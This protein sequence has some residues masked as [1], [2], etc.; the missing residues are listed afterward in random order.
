M[1]APPLMP[2]FAS[3]T[4]RAWPRSPEGGA[5]MYQSPAI[6]LQSRYATDAHVAGYYVPSV[7]RRLDGGAPG[8]PVDGAPLVV[9]MAFLIIDLDGPDHQAPPAWRSHLAERVE[10]ALA[11][12]P[13][14]FSYETRGGGRLV[15][16]RA[17]PF[18]ITTESDARTWK[19]T[20]WRTLLYLSRRYGLVGDPSCADWTRLYRAPHA[21]REPGGKPEQLP[22]VGDPELGTPF[23]FDPSEADLHLDLAE[24]RRLYAAHPPRG[25][26]G[27]PGATGVA[28]GGPAAGA[29]GPGGRPPRPTPPPSF[30][31]D[32]P[33]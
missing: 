15:W 1:S 6:A 7:P 25:G 31:V 20:Y 18:V 24:A 32:A 12:H 33:A 22:T 3:K 13:G 16:R 2:V 4:Y 8:H 5:A 27:R 14:G 30:V 26:G 17:A 29:R 21:T 9:A 28:M 11:E 19:L 23:A 10:R